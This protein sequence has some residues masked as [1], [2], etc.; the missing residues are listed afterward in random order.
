MTNAAAPVLVDSAVYR[1]G[2]RIETIALDRL[3]DRCRDPGCF[4]WVGLYEPDQAS[5]QTVGQA[6]GLHELAVEDA[7]RAHQRPKLEIYG[8]DLFVVLKTVE[9]VEPRVQFGETHIFVGMDYV[10]TVRHHTAH[11]YSGVRKRCE[12]NPQHL[13][14]G[15]DYVLYSVLDYIVDNYM[16]VVDRLEEQVEAVEDRV[17]R[18]DFDRA[19][20]TQIFH[21]KR[22]L[23][24]VRRSLWPMA[25]I[26]ARLMRPDIEMIDPDTY[27]YFRDVQDHVLRLVDSIDHLVD[28][29]DNALEVN[30]LLATLGQ[31]DTTRR[32]AGWAAILAVPTALAG[33]YGMNFE[34]MPEL[35]WSYGYPAVLALMAGVCGTLFWRF[36][37]AG[38]I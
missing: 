2:H 27:P 33:I 25:D 17:L 8:R 20:V 6:F 34:V 7:H 31:N 12:A 30:L 9:T 13:K 29:L 19:L 1:D 3:S 5:L 24:A 15:V 35:T 21:L 10:V 16:P 11:V 4:T 18:Q 28:G 26:A 36:R 14:R 23:M 37:K 22:D 38:W 32:L